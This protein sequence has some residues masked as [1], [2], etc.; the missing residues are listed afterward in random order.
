MEELLTELVQRL[1]DAYSKDLVSVL[2]Y[3]SA[4]ANDHHK[5]HSDLNVLCMLHQVG[6]GELR[7]GEKTMQ[8]WIQPKQPTPLL[9]SV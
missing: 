3:G 9:L 8:W 6:L 1:K 7:K 4:A 5:K 2:L